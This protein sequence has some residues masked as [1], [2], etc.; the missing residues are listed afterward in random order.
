MHYRKKIPGNVVNRVKILEG[1]E[2]ER[3]ST[4]VQKMKFSIKE[5]V[6]TN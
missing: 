5:E 3:R 4:G 2:E 6:K 1:G